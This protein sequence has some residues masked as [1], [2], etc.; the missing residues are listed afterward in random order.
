MLRSSQTALP[1]SDSYQC[2]AE[3]R[4]LLLG[5]KAGINRVSTTTWIYKLKLMYKLHLFSL[6]QGPKGDIGGP[7]FPGP[8]VKHTASF[9]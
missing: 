5:I 3:Q 1:K 4:S 6:K 8:K 9:L 2:S 7:G